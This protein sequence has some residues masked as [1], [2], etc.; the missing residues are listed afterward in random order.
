M[1]NI[2][3]FTIEELHTM[4]D[5]AHRYMWLDLITDITTE[6]DSRKEKIA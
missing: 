6:I 4:L 2:H 1:K 5:I 3:T